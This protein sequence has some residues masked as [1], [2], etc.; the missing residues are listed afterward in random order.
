MSSKEQTPYDQI[1]ALFQAIDINTDG[2][3]N[4]TELLQAV[5]RRRTKEKEL[6]ILFQ[7]VTET[8]PKL[9]SLI[10]PGSVRAALMEMDTDKDGTVNVNEL[11]AF[12]QTVSDD[13]FQYEKGEKNDLRDPKAQLEPNDVMIP[14]DVIAKAERLGINV[15]KET[16]LLWIARQALMTPLPPDWEY[17]WVADEGRALY[18]NLITQDKSVSHPANPYFKQ[19]VMSERNKPVPRAAGMDGAW[20]NFETSLGRTYYYSFTQQ[21]RVTKCPFGVQLL[22]RPPNVQFSALDAPE[23]GNKNVGSS[24]NSTN[25]SSSFSSS[26][27]LDEQSS[28]N[29]RRTQS[30]NQSSTARTGHIR[31]LAVLEFK[32]WW[33]ETVQGMKKGNNRRYM[34]LLFSCETGQFQVILDRSDKVYTLSHIEGKHGPLEAW[35]L[36]VGARINV[37]GRMTTL[38]QASGPTL[39]W[40]DYHCKR[41]QKASKALKRE[42]KKYSM[43][44]ARE[45]GAL[46]AKS[47]K[48]GKGSVCL[49]NILNNIDSLRTR[50]SDFRPKLAENLIKNLLT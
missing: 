2:E 31:D 12:C 6:D 35:D 18:H 42:L 32:S 22:S 3:L 45:Q 21:R 23:P 25:L 33:S 34:D 50:L 20:M 16:H 15:G 38:M 24:S 13:V 1:Y 44:F 5:T 48:G 26:K 41:L 47:D 8:F 49:R 7:Q 9:K 30:G 11:V 37:L 29:R 40:L 43:K 14:E 27:L 4:K 28:D 19:M 39:D 46:M 10:K 36:Y 17:S